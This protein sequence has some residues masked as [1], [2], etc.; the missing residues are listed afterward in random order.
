MKRPNLTASLAALF[1]DSQQTANFTLAVLLTVSKQFLSTQSPSMILP[2][3]KYR[4]QALV[5]PTLN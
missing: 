2:M 4:A 1:S 5:K 3:T